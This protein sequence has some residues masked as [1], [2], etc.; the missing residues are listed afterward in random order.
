MSRV[1]TLTLAM[2]ALASV[3]FGQTP[4]LKLEGEAKWE[5]GRRDQGEKDE[6]VFKLRN[7]GDV[8]LRISKIGVTCGCIRVEPVRG[9]IPAGGE[10]SFTAFLDTTRVAGKIAKDIYIESDAPAQRRLSISVSGE[11]VPQWWLMPRSLNF[12]ELEKGQGGER[13]LRVFVRK[14]RDLKLNRLVSTSPFVTQEVEPFGTK[15]DEEHGYVIRVRVSP[16][17]PAGR[18]LRAHV[19]VNVESKY[20]KSEHF[21]VHADIRGPLEIRPKRIPFGA[22]K[23]GKTVTKSVGIR[24]RN[25]KDLVIEKIFCSDPQVSW[26][27]VEV[28]KGEAFRLDFTLTPD[29]KRTQIAGFVHVR[30]NVDG[31]RIIKLPYRSAV[32]P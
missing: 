14:G 28:R 8:E 24:L 26:K 5:F 25:G 20:K 23:K 2:S 7:P 9:T 32:R 4:E 10:M 21:S 11:I 31:Q 29:G 30:T 3:L 19:T 12:G 22:V 13:E 17:A 18:P 15:D 1:L 27:S 16:K 6:R